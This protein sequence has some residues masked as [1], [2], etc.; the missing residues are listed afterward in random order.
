MIYGH[1]EKTDEVMIRDNDGKN[2][3]VISSE[4]LMKIAW[5]VQCMK[6]GTDLN[7][8]PYEKGEEK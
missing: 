3:V 8:V 1:D 4:F 6:N 5:H 7:G 2:Q